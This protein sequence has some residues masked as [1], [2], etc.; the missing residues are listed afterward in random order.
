ME[1][2]D[3]LDRI[4]R[5]RQDLTYEV[6]LAA[7]EQLSD[8]SRTVLSAFH[9]NFHEGVVG[10]A[11]S[12]LTE[13]YFRPSMVGKIG[14]KTTR[15]SARS[16]PGFHL[17]QALDACS[18]F[19]IR[20]GGH[21]KAAGFTVANE[22]RED[23]LA[24]FEHVAEQQ[25]NEDLLTPR[26]EIHAQIDLE[27]I[28]SRLMTFHDRMEPTG[29]DNPRPLLASRGLRIT[30]RRRVGEDGKHLKLRLAGDAAAID[31]IAFRKGDLYDE[32]PELVDVA[33]RLERNEYRGTIAPQL[34][35]EDIRP[36]SL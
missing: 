25:L 33:F 34:V 15:A 10:L 29:Q 18:E 14:P 1:L 23:F 2:A 12:R 7:T 9:E 24:R 22:R 26:L 4:N 21:E 19:L 30:Y 13:E 17:A 20:Y 35:I 27:D 28:D 5:R 3:H 8:E 11:A 31:A 32:L 16:V 36:A 6:V